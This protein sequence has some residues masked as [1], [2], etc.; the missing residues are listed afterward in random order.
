ME[1]KSIDPM[2][3]AKIMG[4]MYAAMGLIF[5]GLFAV[6]SLAGLS[7]GADRA[8]A[9]PGVLF[10]AGAVI[11]LPIFY[12]CIGFVMGGISAWLYNVFADLIGGVRVDFQPPAS[13]AAPGSR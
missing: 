8:G 7:L 9:F 10:G 5:G 13:A 1:L 2:S 12:G 3:A 11:F 6:I 4:V